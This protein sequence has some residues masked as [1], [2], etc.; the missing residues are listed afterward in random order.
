MVPLTAQNHHPLVPAKLP[1]G[2]QRPRVLSSMGQDLPSPCPSCLQG[3]GPSHPG[4]QNLLEGRKEGRGTED[5][6]EE[7][8]WVK[9]LGGSWR[10]AGQGCPAGGAPH[11]CSLPGGGGGG[12]VCLTVGIAPGSSPFLSLS[13]PQGHLSPPVG[14]QGLLSTAQVPCTGRRCSGTWVK[15]QLGAPR[16]MMDSPPVSPGP[17]WSPSFGGNTLS[18]LGVGGENSPSQSPG[19][20]GL[21]RTCHLGSFPARATL[22][23][24]ATSL[25]GQASPVV[26]P[27]GSSLWGAQAP[28]V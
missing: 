26:T 2:R 12:T 21:L 6:G 27:L 18:M 28:G 20:R 9:R 13:P 16:A 7:G 23:T 5:K 24:G 10:P 8:T 22:P 11:A 1:C 17:G 25:D 19:G 3:P 15:D 4:A 14:N